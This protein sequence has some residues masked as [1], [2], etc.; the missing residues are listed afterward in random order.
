M[1]RLC[2]QALQTPPFLP[3]RRL[4][5]FGHIFRVMVVTPCIAREG[6]P[7]RMFLAG[8]SVKEERLRFGRSG[9]GTQ[10]NSKRIVAVVS[11]TDV[12]HNGQGEEDDAL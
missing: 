3:A 11:L 12:Q 2:W 1:S 8:T 4:P 10:I 5:H 6:S 9:D 7:P